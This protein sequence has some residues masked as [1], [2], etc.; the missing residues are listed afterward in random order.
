ML[1]VLN[2][3]ARLVKPVTVLTM[4]FLGTEER[5]VPSMIRE[6]AN[7]RKTKRRLKI[8]SRRQP[9]TAPGVRKPFING[10]AVTI[11]LV[12]LLLVAQPPSGF[13]SPPRG[14]SSPQASRLGRHPSSIADPNISRQAY[15]VMNGATSVWHLT[16]ATCTA[17]C[18]AITTQTAQSGIH[19]PTSSTRTSIRSSRNFLFLRC[20]SARA[21]VERMKHQAMQ[22]TQVPC[23]ARRDVE[24]LSWATTFCSPT[25]NTTCYSGSRIQ[26]CRLSIA[27]A[28][29]L[30]QL[31][32]PMPGNNSLGRF[33]RV[34]LIPHLFSTR[35]WLLGT[36]LGIWPLARLSVWPQLLRLVGTFKM[37]LDSSLL[38]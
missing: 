1:P 24:E 32:M 15:V 5:R 9:R 26:L 16:S 21:E 19:L 13:T 30:E 17:F 2:S 37:L 22:P 27:P 6:I 34:F 20:S 31:P 18:S 3:H 10:L 7:D 12:S 33:L 38:G 28:H 11:S 35:R 25:S 14:F 23:H 4:M 36:C 8:L 29:V